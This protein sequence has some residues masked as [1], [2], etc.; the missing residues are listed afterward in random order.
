MENNAAVNLKQLKKKKEGN[1]KAV[2]KRLKKNKV[3]IVGMIFLI[4][5]VLMAV[6]AGLFLDYENDAIRQDLKIRNKAPGFTDESGKV[7]IFG[8]DKYG[9]DVFARI[10]FG[11]RMTLVIGFS[12][13]IIA[14]VVGAFL[15]SASGYYGG[16]FDVILMR[17]IEI[18]SSVPGLL[19]T[20]ALVTAFGGGLWQVLVS[21]TFGQIAGFTRLIR[22]S[23]LSVAGLEYVEAARA[24]GAKS[25]H[26]IRKHIIPNVL[27]TILVQGTIAIS[28]NILTG[29]SLG[30]LGIG[31]PLPTPEWGSMM[32]EGLQVMRY[33]SYLVTIPGVFIVVTATAANLFGDGLRDAFDPR[34]KGD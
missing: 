27:G 17:V 33:Y 18:I 14:S 7:H 16:M 29:A 28:G 26:I 2:W 9:R 8:T 1:W 25:G 34:L 10:V 13:T 24:M 22:S 30:F 31:I 12:S 3:A 11:S 23:V 21:I 6:T 15:G 4:L 5:L 20:L 32:Y 19:I